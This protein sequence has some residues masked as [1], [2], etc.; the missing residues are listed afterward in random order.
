[1]SEPLAATGREP[2]AD[3]VDAASAVLEAIRP[4]AMADGDW[5]A[6]VRDA[7]RAAAAARLDDQIVA[8]DTD[9]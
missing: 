5:R 1:M 6:L 2:P 7:L 4:A 9:A 8:N 3:E